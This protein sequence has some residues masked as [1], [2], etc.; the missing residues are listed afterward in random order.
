MNGQELV[1]AVR[2]ERATQLDRL[3]S[4]KYLVAA[5]GADLERAPV[6]RT[7]AESAA[8]GRDTFDAWADEGVGDPATAFGTAAER[9]ADHF[10]RV[11]DSLAALPNDDA[12]AADV[13]DATDDPLHAALADCDGTVERLAAAFVGRPLVADRTRLQVVNFFVNEADERRAE[14]ARDLRADSGDR[15]D[16]G[17]EL[18][19]AACES[20]DDWERA[21]RAAERVVGAAYGAYVD[22]LEAMG[23]DPKPVC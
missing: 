13:I 8:S 23:V 16:E 1:E 2:D 18:L 21:R 17:I 5:T 20:D 19:D 6:L 7:V 4:D 10:D 9:E 12:D 11:V 22:A 3:G 15:L 14:L